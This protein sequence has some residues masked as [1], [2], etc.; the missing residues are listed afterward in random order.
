MADRALSCCVWCA[1]V[2]GVPEVPWV[3][4]QGVGTAV[5]VFGVSQISNSTV[6]TSWSDCCT[7]ASS[8]QPQRAIMFNVGISE[9]TFTG[10]NGCAFNVSRVA[11]SNLF[12]VRTW[13]AVQ[14]V[15][16]HG[17]RMAWQKHVR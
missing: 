6:S 5:C 1:V 9:G 10:D 8:G 15:V 7:N 3:L 14:P 13:S 17:M 16:E 2:Q 4:K 11:S 12:V